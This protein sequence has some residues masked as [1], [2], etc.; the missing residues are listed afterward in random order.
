MSEVSKSFTD[1][2]SDSVLFSPKCGSRQKVHASK[3]KLQTSLSH[4]EGIKFNVET[5]VHR[6]S[7]SSHPLQT[8][9]LS[10][11]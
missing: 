10:L 9:E 11:A 1:S 4:R 5:S 2:A 6:V 8:N 3:C 7:I